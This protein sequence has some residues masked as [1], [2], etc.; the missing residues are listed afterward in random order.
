MAA[1]C[2]RADKRTYSDVSGG[3]G[4]TAATRSKSIPFAKISFPTKPPY[5][6]IYTDAFK[7]AS[8]A[9]KF[10]CTFMEY[11]G[12]KL[13][14]DMRPLYPRKDDILCWEPKGTIVVRLSQIRTRRP[15]VMKVIRGAHAEDEIAVQQKAALYGISPPTYGAYYS[16]ERKTGFILM[17]EGVMDGLTFVRKVHADTSLSALSRFEK[18]LEMT[19]TVAH[20]LLNI[21]ANI[22]T[23]YTDVKL[24]N[25]ILVNN[26]FCFIDFERLGDHSFGTDGWKDPDWRSGSHQSKA[27][28]WQVSLLFVNSLFNRH[29]L[30]KPGTL[31]TEK[32]T[33]EHI[34]KVLDELL[35]TEL[36]SKKEPLFEVLTSGLRLKREDRPTLSE[37]TALLLRTLGSS[38]LLERLRKK[39]VLDFCESV[40]EPIVPECRAAAGAPDTSCAVM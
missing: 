40:D 16:L 34:R 13:L 31:A 17:Q 39:G 35:P 23:Q 8:I 3:D 5:V 18:V 1:A 28:T 22:G 12:R 27:G 15:V 36:E 37:F 26:T 2:A 11:G 21:E 10:G 4:T 9:D 7:V 20:Q 29:V 38:E 14:S 30:R 32:K 24:E 19:A 6:G 25:I 33:H